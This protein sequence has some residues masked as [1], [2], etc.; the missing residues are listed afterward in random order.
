MY[1][2]K[3]DFMTFELCMIKLKGSGTHGRAEAQRF[4][5]ETDES[6]Y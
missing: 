4:D 2:I 1:L 6:I 3:R 5:F